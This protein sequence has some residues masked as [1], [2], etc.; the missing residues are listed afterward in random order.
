VA[1]LDGDGHPDVVIGGLD[2]KVY[3]WDRHGKPLPG[4][5]AAT[6]TPF[7]PDPAHP[8]WES[9]VISSPAVGEL[10]GETKD[11]PE[12]VVGAGDGRVYAYHA[13]GTPLAGWPVLLDDPAQPGFETAKVASSPAI[14]DI[15]GDGRNEVVIG[16][17]ETYG[18]TARVYALRGDGS[19]EKG[20]PVSLG[21]VAPNSRSSTAAPPRWGARSSPARSGRTTTGT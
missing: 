6:R 19:Y 4:W 21:A 18:T 7:G 1:D 17:G 3:A 13:D 20:W 16:D 5:P 12:V 9:T 10:D 2:G 15:D 11:G 14:G 8:H